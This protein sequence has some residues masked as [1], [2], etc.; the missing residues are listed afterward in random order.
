MSLSGKTIVIFSPQPWNYLQ[1]S[2][3]HY[4][5]TLA[6]SN[7]VYYVSP[8]SLKTF[9]SQLSVDGRD[10]VQVVNYTVPLPGRTKFYLPALYRFFNEKFLSKLMKQKIG[11]TFLI[12]DFGCYQHFDT[13]DFAK[14]K[15]KLFFPV[16]DTELLT[17]QRRGA[18]VGITVSRNI[19]RKFEDGWCH[20]I[21]HGLADEFAKVAAEEFAREK[22]WAPSGKLK[23]GYTG[24]VF[25]RFVD[26]GPLIRIISENPTIEFHFFGS[27]EYDANEPWHREW[28]RVLTT[29]S[30][31]TTHGLLTTNELVSR[32][33]DMDAFLVCYKAD[34]KNY[35][36]ENSHKVMEYLSTGKVV[37]S[38]KVSAFAEMGLVQ[39]CDENSEL[40]ALFSRAITDLNELNALPK[41]NLRRSFALEN[42]YEK[43]IEKITALI[44]N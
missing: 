35:H 16:D 8:P 29:S 2:K 20:Y 38:T 30:N 7:T 37:I 31:V 4:A 9:T 11:E 13:L 21:N 10:G 1:I 3:H 40:P 5:R 36:G 22:S 42:T 44:G 39:M 12:I 28:H 26:T 33:R 27:M 32:Y 25:L 34:H 14:A 23:V 19:Q 17:G 24:N 6:K 15:H 18:D 43:N 41:M